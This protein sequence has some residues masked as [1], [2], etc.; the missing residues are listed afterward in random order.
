[1][2]QITKDG[3]IE[4]TRSLFKHTS[5]DTTTVRDIYAAFGRNLDEEAANA[6]W[7][8]NKVSQLRRMNLVNVIYKKFNGKRRLHSIELTYEGRIL[9]GRLTPEERHSVIPLH[10]SFSTSTTVSPSASP[11]PSP[12]AEISDDEGWQ[13]IVPSG[14]SADDFAQQQLFPKL[15]ITLDEALKAILKYNDSHGEFRIDYSLKLR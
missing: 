3:A 8:S 13:K 1:M 5:G 10:G 15:T 9:L 12:S 14:T 6:A 4:R 11:S 2:Q 7:L